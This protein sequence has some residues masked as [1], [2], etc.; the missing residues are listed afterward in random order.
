MLKRI[1][2]LSFA[3]A[4]TFILRA[5]VTT[6]SITGTVTD[7]K[8][9][10][11]AG[12]TITA[13]HTPSGTTYST[14][15]KNGGVFNLPGLRAGGPYSITI[16]S[17][18]FRQQVLDGIKLTL[19]DAY[20]VNVEMISE[21]V[22]LSTIVLTSTK[23]KAAKDI[24]GASTNI[25]QIQLSTLPT[26]SRSITDYTRITP[27][28]NGTSFAGRDNRMNN[29]Q[30]DGANLNN[31]F[32][33]SSDLLPGSGNPISL[34]AYQEISVN[35]SPYDVKQSG[36]TGAGISAITKSGTNT[37]HGSVYGSYRN[38]S[39]NGTRVGDTKLP[40]PAATSNKIY[41]ATIGGPIIKN[42]LFFFL[43]GEIEK[44]SAPG[45]TYSPK[46]GS[47]NGTAS[48]VPI[49]S[50]KVLSDYL[51]SKYGFNPGAYDNFPNFTTDNY[52]ILAKLD[53]N[54]SRAH[55][56][57]LKYSDFR[58]TGYAQP[59][60]S[61][62]IN[63]ASSQSSIISYTPTPGRFGPNSMAF[64]NVNYSIVDKV[65]SGALELNSNFHGKF[66]NQFI[67]TVTKISSIKGHDGATF[68]FV[69]IIGLTAGSKNNY[70]SFGNEPFNGNNNQ[71]INDVYT[72]T[73]NFS[74]YA[75]RHTITA[76]ATYEYQKV[77]N[78]FMAGSQGYYVYGSLTD[79]L[80]NAAPKLFSLTY[81][82]KE[83][84]DAVFSAN[85]KIGQLGVYLQ[86]EVNINPRFK[87]TYGLRIDRPIYPEEPLENPAISVLEL[88]D[89]NG[90]PTQYTTGR[91][92]FVSW[93]YSPRVGFRWDMN[94]DKS[95][96]LRGGSGLFT[97]RIPFVYLTNVPSGSGM[98]QFGSL[99]TSNL[100]NFLFNPDPHAYNPFYNTTLNPSQFPTKAGTV[101]PGSFAVTNRRFKFPQV[102][103]TNIAIDQSLGKGW[104]LTIEAL[105]SKDINDPIMRN[106]NQKA[107]DTVVNIAPGV[108]R[109]RYSSTNARRLYTGISN[110]IVLDNT[111]KGGSF[112]LTALVSKSF[113]KG[114]Y[115]S[116]AYTYTHAVDV[117][118][119][120]GSQATSTW[121]GIY[122]SKTQ[123]DQELAYSQ[124]A[125]PHRIV[126]TASYRIE[127][128]K[129]LASTFTIYY[130]G[131]T[132]GTYSYIYNGDINNDG[133]SSDLMYI[134]KDPSEIKFAPLTVNATGVTYTA[135][136]QSDLFFKYIA[137]DKY[138]SKHMGQN[139]ERNG[140]K[141]PWYHRMDFNFQQ[142]IFNNFGKQRHT[143]QFNAA[144]IN[145][146]NLLNKDWGIRKQYI[147]NNPLRVA[148]V[149]NGVP[150]FQLA[151]FNNVPV[152]STYINVNSTTT[153]W[154]IQLGLKYIF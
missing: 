44:S 132:Q 86:D 123:N 124:Y 80:N 92:P 2:L 45:V 111:N 32:G 148:S 129:H 85:M 154:G 94:G 29:V 38:Q 74:Y 107:P 37:F 56:L 11:I 81:S 72:V 142:D 58:N 114:F 68:P 76:G 87:L 141:Y 127:Y 59:S 26:I 95:M 105:Y 147:V 4:A 9:E 51:Q 53:W 130:E 34:D 77:G 21:T 96:I 112:A 89:K 101:A 63:G 102:W 144:V 17:V 69:D 90:N 31:N 66:S 62:G 145:F 150:S 153:T 8:N 138:L 47:G 91:W 54:I 10:P 14:V 140:A 5:Q 128:I 18:G 106:A 120:P 103:R 100:S 55:K 23:R 27:Q 83:G 12:A 64:N 65:R 60:A 108:V 40:S 43:N 125:V 42:K 151:T 7:G 73:D 48:N 115:G 13:V 117:S 67:A 25:S 93:Y 146:L 6:S 49:D 52:K 30:V 19:G 110:A 24:A 16:T 137:Q 139:A 79:F 61:G 57:T 143:L 134:P 82:L 131:A 78:M 22:D 84:Q 50:L 149:T 122:T 133:N 71:V 46:G 88:S 36:F 39:Y 152:S 118:P 113:L 70:L 15:S 97:G 33:L 126:A 20:N 41:G 121:S 35:I 1:A 98:Y 136:Q 116:L 109:G 119:N 28:A 135:Q 3:I 104:N 99:V 75:G